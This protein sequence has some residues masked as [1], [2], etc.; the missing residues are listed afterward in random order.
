[1]AN[2]L[3]SNPGWCYFLKIMIETMHSLFPSNQRIWW[4]LLNDLLLTY[5]LA[6][7]RMNNKLAVSTILLQEWMIVLTQMTDSSGYHLVCQQLC[8]LNGGIKRNIAVNKKWIKASNNSNV[9]ISL[10]N[11]GMQ[12][13]KHMGNMHRNQKERKHLTEKHGAI[14]MNVFHSQIDASWHTF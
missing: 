2:F 11:T 9:C 3:V 5:I 12:S 14:L 8:K 1:M 13:Q 10:M 6:V 4:F 7:H